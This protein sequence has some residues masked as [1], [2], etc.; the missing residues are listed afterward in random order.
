MSRH[1]ASI[2]ILHLIAS[3]L[4]LTLLAHPGDAL[5]RQ[6][7][8]GD[9]LRHSP[10]SSLSFVFTGDIM[11]HQAQI[12]AAAR[13]RGKYDYT[14]SFRLIAPY[15]QDADYT[16]GN[17]E[18]TLGGK[19]YRGYPCFSAPDTLTH[20]LRNAGFDVLSTANNHSC[21]RRTKGVLRTISQLDSAR[22]LHTGTFKGKAGRKLRTPLMLQKH[23][24]GLVV[25]FL[26]YTYGT[27]GIKAKLPAVVNLIDTAQ[28]ASDIARAKKRA[29]AVI[30][31][32]HWGVEY[33][34]K[35]TTQQRQLADFLFRQGV[36]VIVGNHPHV[37]Q[38]F[39]VRRDSLGRIRQLCVYALGNFIS[40]Q[41]TFPRAGGMLL[42]LRLKRI[43]GGIAIDMPQYL[44]TYVQK[45][46][47]NHT[48][49]FR[50]VPLVE[51]ERPLR[52]GTSYPVRYYR[53]A[54]HT[55]RRTPKGIEPLR[56][57]PRGS[58]LPIRPN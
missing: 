31:A 40:A 51:N 55:L 46:S 12:K 13:P 15:L 14:E 35:P 1:L 34:H 23:L 44:L 28:M 9:T 37:I 19:P 47:E 18:L 7:V 53:R 5:D 30:V 43:Q 33:T 27:N 32:V 3:L 29:E 17:L 25:A 26:S 24:G 8:W 16:V 56:D 10:D 38:P 2:A 52:A 49:T 11:Q 22:L 57:L 20:F 50:V 36:S 58:L 4:P 39:E 45:P 48:R 42:R 41:R 54:V 6:G 21:D